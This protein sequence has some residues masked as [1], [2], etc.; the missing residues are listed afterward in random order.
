VIGK[1]VFWVFF[2]I[3]MA[4]IM[5]LGANAATLRGNKESCTDLGNLV[6]VA[7]EARDAGVT[8]DQI[9]IRVAEMVTAAM[10]NKDSYIQTNADAAFVV[11]ALRRLWSD[12]SEPTYITATKIYHLCMTRES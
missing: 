7:G 10:S 11:S 4:L 1:Y 5:I 6:V 3:V 9:Q 12:K 8:W 2:C